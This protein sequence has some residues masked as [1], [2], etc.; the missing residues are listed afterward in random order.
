[1]AR[2]C[3]CGCGGVAP[4]AKTTDPRK[5]AIKGMSRRFIRGHGT[6]APAKDGY[7]Q[8]TKCNRI[9]PLEKYGLAPR[10]A[11]GRDSRC[12]E[13]K[14]K[15]DR[16]RRSRRYREDAEFREREKRYAN[17]YRIEHSEKRKAYLAE[18]LRRPDVK[19]ALAKAKRERLLIPK[20]NLANR[21]RCRIRAALM[22][23]KNGQSW[24]SLVPYGSEELK[25][26]IAR[27]FE[28]GMS[29]GNMGKWHIDHI[30]PIAAFKFSDP[31]DVGFQDCFALSNLRPIWKRKNLQKGSKRLFLI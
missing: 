9:L 28:N 14:R 5:G 1:M 7:K 27:C 19:S 31:K 4:I 26:H 17:I 23:G 2:L 11:I 18:Y 30:R 10:G 8:C 13:C 15:H 21:M 3:E 20:W 24:K 25:K 22:N 12:S 6:R 29:W 16:E